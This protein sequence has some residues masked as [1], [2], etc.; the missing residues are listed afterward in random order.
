MGWR[1]PFKDRPMIMGILNVTPDSFY[2]GGQFPDRETA[3]GHALRMVDE[4][5]DIIDI[6][7]ESTRPYAQPTPLHEELQRVI[8][9][10]EGI[11]AASDVLISVDTYKA[12]V[13][14]EALGA[15]ANMINDISGLTYDREMAAAAADHGCPVVLM[16]IKG[17]PRDMQ[18]DP[19]Y[20][21]VVVEIMEFFRERLDYAAQSGI[22]RE[23]IIL[24]P[25]FGFGK[26]V[27]DNLRILKG[28]DRFKALGCPLLVG[29]SMKSTIGKV[30]DSPA[31][32]ERVE[33]TMA[34]VAV[35]LMNGADIV[36]VHDVKRTRKVAMFVQAMMK[37]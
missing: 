15:G 27:E 9:V 17:T 24:D 2:D 30:T 35:A 28:L 1:K 34:S 10:I 12:S 26:R 14:H 25:G 16:H 11:R 37:A 8:P 7:G 31:F 13:A 3:V 33:G 4:G 18:A 23:N 20:D 19:Y 5:A 32:E 22:S 36:R 6:G 29:T 21:D